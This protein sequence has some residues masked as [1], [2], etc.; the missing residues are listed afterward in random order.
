MKTFKSYAITNKA[1]NEPRSLMIAY[2]L[3]L[4]SFLMLKKLYQDLRERKD[5]FKIEIP[6]ELTYD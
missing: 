4:I 5:I 3:C 6:I 2:M 1:K